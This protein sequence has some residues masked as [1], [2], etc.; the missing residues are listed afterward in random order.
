MVTILMWIVVIVV[1]AL[2]A[3]S[4]EEQ[5]KRRQEIEDQKRAKSRFLK[6]LS[7]GNIGALLAY[8]AFSPVPAEVL[9]PSSE[10]PP[11][12]LEAELIWRE[13]EKWNTVNF[14]H[15]ISSAM[16]GL[17]SLTLVYAAD[18]SITVES[19]KSPTE[20]ADY[21]HPPVP[22]PFTPQDFKLTRPS[23]DTA[24]LTYKVS[25]GYRSFNATAVW[26]KRGGN[27]V[28]VSYQVTKV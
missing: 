12:G 25:S 22:T 24:T 11:R 16:V 13:T 9:E 7:E 28:T 27:W 5:Q 10:K 14:A 19:A 26:I 17:G 6:A 20:P 18:G 8:G 3:A 15:Q 21:R 2:I 1:F 23:P 4:W